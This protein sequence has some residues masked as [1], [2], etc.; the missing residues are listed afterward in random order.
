MKSD[1]KEN[2]V[3]DAMYVKLENRKIP[4]GERK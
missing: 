2:M 3:H 4:L 1:T